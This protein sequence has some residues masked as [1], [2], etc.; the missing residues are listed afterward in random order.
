MLAIH[1]TTSDKMVLDPDAKVLWDKYCLCR[2]PS[3]MEY[4]QMKYKERERMKLINKAVNSKLGS[5]RK[6]ARSR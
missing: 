3:Y 5:V 1:V 2:K 6:L 4:D